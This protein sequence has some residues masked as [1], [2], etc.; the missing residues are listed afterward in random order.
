MKSECDGCGKDIG[1]PLVKQYFKGICIECRRSIPPH[2]PEEQIM[3]WLKHQFK[4]RVLSEE[5]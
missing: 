4:E 1:T 5:A 2:I 3:I